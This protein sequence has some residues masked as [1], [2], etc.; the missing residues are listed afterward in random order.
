MVSSKKIIKGISKQIYQDRNA[1]IRQRKILMQKL[2][3]VDDRIKAIDS[4]KECIDHL[5]SYL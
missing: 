1:E 5:S 2:E 3:E 4:K